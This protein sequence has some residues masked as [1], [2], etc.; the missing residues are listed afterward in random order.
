MRFRFNPSS[1]IM[2]TTCSASAG[3]TDAQNSGAGDGVIRTRLNNATC[4]SVLSVTIVESNEENRS[5]TNKGVENVLGPFQ[6][7]RVGCF[8]WFVSTP[9]RKSKYY[10]GKEKHHCTWHHPPHGALLHICSCRRTFSDT[11]G[12]QYVP[13]RDGLSFTFF[14]FV[15][16]GSGSTSPPSRRR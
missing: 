6:R 11:T 4:E 8:V 13:R 7:Q 5:N 2:V 10:E 1:M 9:I 14:T 3:L 16:V 15:T 12:G